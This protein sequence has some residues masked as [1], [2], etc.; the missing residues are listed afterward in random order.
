MNHDNTHPFVVQICYKSGLILVHRLGFNWAI[1]G[2]IINVP[3]MYHFWNTNGLLFGSPLGDFWY[4][5]TVYQIKPN[6]GT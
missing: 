4:I 3:F 2:T 5:T 1:F 6:S